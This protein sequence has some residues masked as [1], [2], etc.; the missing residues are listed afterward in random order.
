LQEADSIRDIGPHAFEEKR[1]P[2]Q[3]QTT[4]VPFFLCLI[5]WSRPVK[6]LFGKSNDVRWCVV[7]EQAYPW[8]QT[9]QALSLATFFF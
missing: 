2:P 6:E 1:C 7:K 9:K 3:D 5:N 8:D 4:G